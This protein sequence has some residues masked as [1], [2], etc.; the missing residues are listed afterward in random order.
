MSVRTMVKKLTR[1]EALARRRNDRNTTVLEA[2]AADPVRILTDAGM[3]PDSWQEGVLRSNASRLLLLASRQAGKSSVAAALALQTALL[4]PRSPVLLLS[5]SLR[6]SGELYRKIV[7]LFGALGRPMGVTAESA[8]RLELANG[9]R[10]VS[11]PGDEKNIRGF[12]GVALLVIDEASRVAD[13][14]YYAVRPMLAVSRG[15]L[16]ALS[17][18]FGKRGWYH[19]EWY[20]AGA[21]ERV[22]IT[23]DQCPRISAEFLA[24]ER[25]ALGER[26]YR[27]EYL[28]SFEDTIDAV[29][30]WADIQAAL[31]DDVKPLFAER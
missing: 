29:F 20:S 10:V 25:R 8:L 18:P 3:E 7:D 15:R 14:L 13:S 31:S 5:P 16:V 4:R 28:C 22:K 9:S 30:S 1:L 6:Q 11:L 23:A 21:W 17:T 12:S 26:W 19:D 27:Q 24:E 2:L